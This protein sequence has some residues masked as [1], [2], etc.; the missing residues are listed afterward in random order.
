M[1]T[2]SFSSR[3]PSAFPLTDAAS[4]NPTLHT[5]NPHDPIYVEVLHRN[6]DENDGTGYDLD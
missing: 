2:V 4:L 5:F 3:I 6:I 1:P